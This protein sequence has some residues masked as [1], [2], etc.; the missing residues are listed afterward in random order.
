MLTPSFQTAEIITLL[1]ESTLHPLNPEAPALNPT[2]G[3]KVKQ[4]LGGLRFH[5]DPTRP[6]GGVFVA[7]DTTNEAVDKHLP[8]GTIINEGETL[9]SSH[10]AQR[11]NAPAWS[12]DGAAA[13]PHALHP[14][15]HQ[16][17]QQHAGAAMVSYA[18]LGASHPNVNPAM[19]TDTGQGAH[20]AI[21]PGH[22]QVLNLLDQ[23]QSIEQLAIAD[24]GFLEGMPATI[25]D[26]G[27]YRVCLI[28][29]AGC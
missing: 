7:R 21:P 2:G 4:P 11:P 16:Q 22:V 12:L 18:P 14:Q 28:V 5:K 20:M 27:A 10:E 26:W 3:V 23:P 13:S 8:Q 6:G 1:Y 15:H 29:F 19:N 25:F 24:A 17:Q 9:A